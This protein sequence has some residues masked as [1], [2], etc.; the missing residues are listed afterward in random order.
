[1]SAIAIGAAAG[2]VC[3]FALNMKFKLGY[4]DSLDA[5]GVHGVGGIIGSIGAGV[6]ASTL[7]NP[8]GADGLIFGNI[9]PVLTQFKA[10]AIVSIYSVGVSYVLLKILDMTIGLRVEDEDEIQGLDVS[11]HSEAGY[12]LR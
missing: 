8:A 2:L 11:Q 10:L 5:F 7:I 1:M 6:F 4:D 9:G 3:Y 12:E